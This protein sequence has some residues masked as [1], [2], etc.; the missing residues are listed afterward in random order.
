MNLLNRMNGDSPVSTPTEKE[1]GLKQNSDA[2]MRNS[3]P[4][5]QDLLLQK[6]SETIQKQA[7]EIQQLSGTIQDMYSQ[8]ER[9]MPE[10]EHLRM[11]GKPQDQEKTQSL[12]SENSMLLK[13]L[14]EK[15]ETIV[16]LNERIGTL[17]NSNLIQQE[18]IENLKQSNSELM[19]LEQSTREG[20]DARVLIVKEE[21]QKKEAELQSRINAANERER[22]AQAQVNER[23]ALIEKLAEQKVAH[24]KRQLN[25]KY[26][27]ERETREK[28]HNY[29]VKKLESRYRGKEFR[30]YSLTIGGL[31]YGF[32]ATIFT[33]V[34]SPRFSSDAI[35]AGKFIWDYIFML[36]EAA[37]A[38]FSLAWSLNEKIPVSILNVVVPGILAVLGFLLL[39][40]GT[41]ATTGFII[42]LICRLYGGVADRLSAAVA[43]VSLAILV[44]F[45]DSL[46]ILPWNLLLVFLISHAAYVLLRMLFAPKRIH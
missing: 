26:E 13:E 2:T 32:L 6:Q 41:L 27:E 24:A 7:L 11:L 40:C 3:N 16:S 36:W 12:S 31:L 1:N 23:D 43:L 20:A 42:Y 5:P 8:M 29:Q 33:A 35:T 45:A 9:I 46:T 39:F 19:R 21:Y 34:N 10:L 37:T 17:S 25:Q 15:S 30:L 4:Q 22:Q 14:Q 44:W 28:A 18:E 38:V